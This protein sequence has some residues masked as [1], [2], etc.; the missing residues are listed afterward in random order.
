M[1]T[2]RVYLLDGDLTDEQMEAVKKALIN[3]VE[4]REASLDRPETL[5]ADYEIPTTVKTLDGFN[6]LDEDG[7]CGLCEGVRPGD[8]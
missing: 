5:K 6:A 7:A 8:G 2:A 4:A 1:R 3:P